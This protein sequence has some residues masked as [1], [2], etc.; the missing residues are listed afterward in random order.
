MRLLLDE[1][2]Q[3]GE[4]ISKYDNFTI[5]THVNPDGDTVGSA[6]ALAQILKRYN[7]TFQIVNEGEIPTKLQFLPLADTIIKS[8][9][10]QGN[11]EN[12]ITVDCADKR[13]VGDVLLNRMGS[14]GSILMNIDHHPTNDDYAQINIINPEAASTTM[15]LYHLCKAIEIPFDEDLALCIYTGLMTDTGCFRYSNTNSDVHK[16]ASELISYG[17]N[18][19][20]IVDKIYETVPLH[21]IRTLKNSL[22]TLDVDDTGKIAWLI[23]NLNDDEQNTDTEGFINYPRSIEGIEV[24]LTFKVIDEQAIKIG[25]RSKSYADVSQIAATFGGGGH[26]R[27]AG[28][29]LTGSL[30]Q[31]KNQVIAEIKKYIK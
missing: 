22:D 27:A 20:D 7:K 21:S 26:K 5:V 6:L 30:E 12:V 9:H 25:L 13:R 15:I 29:T 16:V 31:V 19:Y 18:V 4:V 3:F 14:S 17:I 10:L 24:A 8:E 11:I 2:K 23:I 28:C 1:Y